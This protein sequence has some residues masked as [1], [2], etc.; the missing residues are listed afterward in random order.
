MSPDSVLT[1]EGVDRLVSERTAC[2]I[3]GCSRSYLARSRSEGDRIGRTPGPPFIRFP[4]GGIRYAV[5]DL[6]T[7][8]ESHRRRPTPMPGDNA[9]RD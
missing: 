9:G 3:L 5:R 1:I 6:S 7:W 8:I 4:G 2:R